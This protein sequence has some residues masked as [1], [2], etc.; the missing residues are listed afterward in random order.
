[1]SNYNINSQFFIE[2]SILTRRVEGIYKE[3]IQTTYTSQIDK[4][5]V[6]NH[7]Y[8]S[9]S[10]SGRGGQQNGHSPLPFNH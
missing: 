5:I 2:C 9:P 1:M 3:Y 4:Y 8:I 10:W 7:Y 6:R